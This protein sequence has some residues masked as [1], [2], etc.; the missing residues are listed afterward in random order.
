RIPRCSRLN[1]RGDIRTICICRWQIRGEGAEHAYVVQRSGERR[2]VGIGRG[3]YRIAELIDGGDRRRSG[4]RWDLKDIATLP[5][6][7]VSEDAISSARRQNS[8]IAVAAR[9]RQQTVPEKEEKRLI[10]D[11]RSAQASCVLIQV[12]PGRND[13]SGLSPVVHPG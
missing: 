3:P 9:S 11:N 13:G 4:R 2:A 12:C 5:V 10:F 1:K 7:E 8:S 6:V